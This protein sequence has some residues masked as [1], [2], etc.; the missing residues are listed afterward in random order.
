ML[1]RTSPFLHNWTHSF[2]NAMELLVCMWICR[3]HAPLHLLPN[4]WIHLCIL[5][6]INIY[7]TGLHTTSLNEEH[8]KSLL[9]HYHS[10]Y[11]QVF[12]KTSIIIYTNTYVVQQLSNKLHIFHTID[13]IFNFC[14]TWNILY[15][16]V[17]WT[18]E[19]DI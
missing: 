18:H 17:N 16:P 2:N 13:L 15:A 9:L 3:A 14:I 10:L 8:I 1:H 5:V 4:H 7:K 12:S 6:W 11:Q 19:K